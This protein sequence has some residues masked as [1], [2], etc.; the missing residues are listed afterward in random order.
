M[1]H[2]WKTALVTITGTTL[3]TINDVPT[4]TGEVYI[5]RGSNANRIKLFDGTSQKHEIPANSTDGNVY[6][7]GGEDGVRYE[8]SLIISPN[9]SSGEIVVHYTDLE[10]R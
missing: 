6:A 8:T 7:F 5:N 9:S 2:E 3:V 1:S 4:L 10:R